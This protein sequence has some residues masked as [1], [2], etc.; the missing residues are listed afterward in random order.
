MIIY[1]KIYFLDRDMGYN[2]RNDRRGKIIRKLSIRSQLMILAGFTIMVVLFIIF[3]T[4]SMM[5]GMVTRNHDEYVKTTVMEIKQTVEINKE[6]I[7]RLMQN[8]SFNEDVQ[9]YLVDSTYL[10]KFELYKRVDGFLAN[11]KNLLNGILDIAIRGEEDGSWFDIHGG[12][13]Y[14][15]L[16]NKTIPT[17]ANAY[18]VGMQDFGNEYGSENKMIYATKIYYLEQGDL[19]NKEIGTLYFIVDTKALAGEQRY[20][21]KQTNTQIYL[22]EKDHKVIASNSDVKI[23]APIPNLNNEI[24]FTKDT[25]ITWNN[26]EYDIQLEEL[27]AI[28]GSILS[29]TPKDEL[30]SE[31][32]Y[33]RRLELIILVSGLLLLT[34]PF[35]FIV[36]N[37]IFPVKKL[38]RFMNSLKR[39][40]LHKLKKRISLAGYAEI[41]VVATQFNNMLDEIDL[42]TRNLL[43]TNAR[44]YG[45][46][47]EKEKA[48]LAFLRS[49]INPHFLYNTLEVIS[50]IAVV[51]GQ[52]KIKTMTRALASIFRYSVKGTNVVPLKSELKM[53]ESFVNIQQIRF[54]NRFFVH[55]DFTEEALLYVVPKMFLQPL[56]E[57]AIYHGFEPKLKIGQLNIIGF[58]NEHGKLIINVEDNGVGIAP[59]R[60][61]EIQRTLSL[62]TFGVSDPETNKNIGIANVNNRIKLMYGNE[63]GMEIESIHGIGTKIRLTIDSRGSGKGA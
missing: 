26:K 39:G 30:L 46:E 52:S 45:I 47:L 51:E 61:Q 11:Q 24:N 15:S 21:S 4:Y 19:F 37:I 18:Y 40:D 55:Y 44:L 2:V 23:G 50:G 33:I 17:K 10:S 60:L 48:E 63:C 32:L 3:F 31:L 5:S 35:M 38:I 27:P 22:L 62:S 59:D 49:Q 28:E 20:S 25:T 58:V 41:S 14:V 43:D 36:N 12:S 8:I 6:N 13:N 9:N 54:N 56:V 53:I 29:I 16:L 42:L 34:I 7:Y 57:N 1:Q